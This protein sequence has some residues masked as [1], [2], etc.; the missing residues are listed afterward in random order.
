MNKKNKWQKY[1]RE[2]IYF[3]R[4]QPFLSGNRDL[5]AHYFSI[6]FGIHFY[7]SNNEMLEW[8]YERRWVFALGNNLIDNFCKNNQEAKKFRVNW[9]KLLKQ[10]RQESELILFEINLKKLSKKD[11]LI[12]F[13]KW[14]EAINNFQAITGI[15]VDF[16]D[17]ALLVSLRKELARLIKNKNKFEEAFKIITTPIEP[18][19]I[20]KRDLEIMALAREILKK[21]IN[22]EKLKR[23]IKKIEDKFW[24]TSLGWNPGNKFG[25]KDI[26]QEIKKYLNDKNLENKYCQL[27]K[28]S[29]KIKKDK[30]ILL[31]QIKPG[32]K[33]LDL[34]RFFENLAVLHDE[35]KEGQMKLIAAGD[36][37]L[38]EIAKRKK[39][40]KFD[41]LLLLAP[42]E[43]AD[44]FNKGNE[45]TN[46]IL[47][48]RKKYICCW[49][50]STEYILK[51]GDEALKM[52][53]KLF[54]QNENYNIKE[55]KGL[56]A[57]RGQAKANVK[58]GYSML[59]LSKKFKVGDI[60][61]VPQTT[62]DF[63]PLMKKSAAVITDEGGATC[64]AA[65]ISRE[66][67]IPCIVGTKIATQVL[68]DGDL[69]EVDANQGVVRI[70]DK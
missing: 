69:V 67:G 50:T 30:Q 18:T 16:L 27:K 22:S 13:L 8:Y 36:E 58:V 63:V 37:F 35:R 5:Y 14:I 66:L 23:S 20:T 26:K 31:R 45:K 2:N 34:A 68:K 47:K 12:K 3:N 65:I 49:T 61:V 11:L 44:Y 6:P 43:A 7:Y 29:Q 19:Y 55:L 51:Q 4:I 62:P 52:R 70:I 46:K 48:A 64:H 1:T 33:F 25:A 57:S 21:N 41:D 39:E 53:T 40:L 60:L 54:S 32:R 38:R 10:A 59:V 42:E 28:F 9:N 56:S 17:E 15:G 24:W